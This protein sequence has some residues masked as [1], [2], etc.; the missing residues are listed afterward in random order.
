MKDLGQILFSHNYNAYGQVKNR[1]KESSTWFLLVDENTF[2]L[3]RK[4][5]LDR[6]DL[7]PDEVILLSSGEEHKYFHQV[8]FIY[9]KMM[10]TGADRKSVIVNL[11]GGLLSDM[12]GFAASTF[13]RG[14]DYVNIPT[15]LLSMVDAS[16]GGKTG[17]N[18]MNSKN[19]IGSFHQPAMVLV[20]PNYLR[21]LPQAEV[22]SGFGEVVKHALIHDNSLWSDIKKIDDINDFSVWSSVIARAQ[23]IKLDIVEN[24]P[25]EKGERKLLNFGHTIGHALESVFI[26][27]E[28]SLSHGHAVAI[29]MICEA[30]LS[31]KE[32]QLDEREFLEIEEFIRKHFIIPSVSKKNMDVL[33]SFLHHDKKNEDGKINFTLIDRIGEGVID[34]YIDE[35]SIKEV[36]ISTFNIGDA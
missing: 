24:D 10:F 25:F 16:V 29:G 27:N 12:G 9:E 32:G 11:G 3:C 34:N 4:D 28:K 35:E 19:Q 30:S 7:I 1:L 36:L 22:L 15:T 13:K 26:G 18:F 33:L 23:Q 17:I 5:F 31:V 2:K 6:L 8:E 21:T 20:D 14:I